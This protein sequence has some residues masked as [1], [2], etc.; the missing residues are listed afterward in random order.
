[1]DWR[2]GLGFT[3]RLRVIQ[4]LLVAYSFCRYLKLI[5]FLARRPT[6]KLPLPPPSRKHSHKR[7]SM[8]LRRTKM[9][10]PRSVAQFRNVRAAQTHSRARKSM[11]AFAN[12]Q[13]MLPRPH[14]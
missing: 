4:S 2:K 3:D 12:G 7:G 6:S 5:L 11:T 13:L 10:T 1:M 9:P 8:R 14:L